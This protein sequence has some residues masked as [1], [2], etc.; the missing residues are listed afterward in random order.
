[1][2]PGVFAARNEIGFA[3]QDSKLTEY[4]TQGQAT[5]ET[6]SPIAS[7]VLSVLPGNAPPSVALYPF[8]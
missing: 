7:R 5:F 4:N 2:F 6:P 3:T 8:E 1:L